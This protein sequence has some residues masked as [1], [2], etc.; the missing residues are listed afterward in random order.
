MAQVL[1]RNL[2]DR[3]VERLK[4]KAA[5]RGL[6]LEGFLR[7]VLAEQARYDREEF[8]RRAAEIRARCRPDPEGRDSTDLIRK[9][10]DERGEHLLRVVEGDDDP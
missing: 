8:I 4:E 7:G 5:A 2:D 10:R 6:S 9:M 1:V 3:V